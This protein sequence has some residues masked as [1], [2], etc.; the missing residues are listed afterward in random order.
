MKIRL[1]H[2]KNTRLLV[3]VFSFY[4]YDVTPVCFDSDFAFVSAVVTSANPRCSRICGVWR[5]IVAFIERVAS[6][7]EDDAASSGGSKKGA[8][9]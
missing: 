4:C 6:Y 3:T 7:V 9:I 8:F 1:K 5:R 2:A